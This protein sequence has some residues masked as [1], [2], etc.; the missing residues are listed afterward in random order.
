LKWKSNSRLDWAWRGLDLAAAVHY[1]DGFHEYDNQG[2]IHYVKQTWFFDVRGSY[3]LH[4][5]P[6]A[7]TNSVAGYSKAGQT[8]PSSLSFGKRL[9]NRTTIT[10]G[11]NNVFGHDPPTASTPTKLRRFPLRFDRP[12]R[13]REPNEKVLERL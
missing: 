1:L 10:L 7:E 3:I 13:L 6:P 8:A 4:L 11:C 2:L 9:L 12:L 5:A